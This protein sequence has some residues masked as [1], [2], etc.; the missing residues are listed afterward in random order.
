MIL[1]GRDEGAQGGRIRVGSGKMERLFREAIEE[2][3]AG[4]GENSVM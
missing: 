2:L 1:V 4:F 3:Q